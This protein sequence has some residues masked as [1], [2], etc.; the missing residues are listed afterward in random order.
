MI[1]NII[2]PT[3]VIIGD[4]TFGEGNYVG[5]HSVLIGPLVLGDHN[6]VSNSVT[7]G[8]LGED[9]IYTPE[10]HNPH[11]NKEYTIRI[12]D[13]NVFREYMTVHR[14]LVSETTVGNDNYF[15]SRSHISH[16]N[17]IENHVKIANNVAIGGFS[18]IQDCSYLGLGAV[19]H[20]FSIIGSGC[21]I[22]MNS[23]V[24]KS[25]KPGALALGQPARVMRPNVIGL[26]KFDIEE[27]DWWE[28][29]DE[30]HPGQYQVL[31]EKYDAECVRRDLQRIEIQQWRFSILQNKTL[32]F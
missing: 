9:D 14:G 25:I 11:F 28:L 29:E 19:L 5:H 13:R 4:V 1:E 6:Y 26:G 16:D 15:M 32:N 18:T 12:G 30:H 3:A 27:T 17:R 10:Q 21:M 8:T 22:G 20:Q 24:T 2:E 31:M 7:I 23:T